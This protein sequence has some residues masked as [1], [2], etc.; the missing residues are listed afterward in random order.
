MASFT[1]KQILGPTGRKR[2]LCGLIVFMVFAA[3]SI[4][5]QVTASDPPTESMGLIAGAGTSPKDSVVA[6]EPGKGNISGTITDTNN[7]VIPGVTVTLD[8]PSA[9]SS[10]TV[11][12]NDL[13]GFDFANLDPGGPY[14]VSI[15]ADGLVSWT[16]SAVT[17]KPGQFL[18]LSNIRMS[19]SGGV[20]SVTVYASSEQLATE[21]VHL[22]EKQ[23]VLGLIPNFYVVYDQNP[24]PLTSKLKFHLALR[25]L[26]DPVSYIG[27]FLNAGIYQAADYPGYRGGM[28][29][30]GQ[31]LG[32]TFAGGYTHVLVE[33]ALLPSLLHQDPRY[34]YQG[35]G[36]T[37]SR[38]L[39]AF[40]SAVFATGDNGRREIN[41]SGIGGD[42][43][44][45]AIANLYYP[46]RERGGALVLEDALIGTG[47]RVAFSVAEEF[48]LKRHT[49]R[50]GGP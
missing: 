50:R 44:S 28:E 23:R 34:Y 38:L 4:A 22:E 35:T 21:Q 7:D 20:T 36:T 5:Q 12:A 19:F 27:F 48:L 6:P 37:R 16:S 14:Y 18:N 31:R 10:R 2:S 24:A 33:D 42:L 11:V 47:G 46:S 1:S 3:S 29:G 39:H 45:G 32:A 17:L 25:T 13:G 43:A 9:D 40:S 30:F 49:T 8:G 41:Y 26:N 15:K